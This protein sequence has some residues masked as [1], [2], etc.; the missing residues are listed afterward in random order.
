MRYLTLIA[1][2]SLNALSEYRVYQYALKNTVSMNA[3][4]IIISTL[5]PRAYLAYNGIEGINIDLLRTWICPGYTG[6]RKEI[7]PSPYKS[8]M[9]KEI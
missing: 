8:L 9:D 6:Q 1:M 5:N 2:F 7:C 3:T 4:N